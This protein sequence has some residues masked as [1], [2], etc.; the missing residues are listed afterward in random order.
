MAAAFAS[1]DGFS[2]IATKMQPGHIILS[3]DG[4]CRAL[5]T[6]TFKR[7]L[8]RSKTSTLELSFTY[9]VKKKK[10]DRSKRGTYT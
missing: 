4:L 10:E 3:P 2:F 8:S 1:V 9:N 5:I 6:Y 7:M